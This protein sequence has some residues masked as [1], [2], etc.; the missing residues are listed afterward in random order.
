M[1]QSIAVSVL[2]TV[3]A[4]RA[5][6]L[7]AATAL[8]AL[9]L[10]CVPALA[11]TLSIVTKCPPDAV[12][13]GQTCV[14]TYEASVWSVPNP[15]TTN[16]GLIKKII[17]GKVKLSDLGAGS[18]TQISFSLCTPAFPGTFPANGQW[19]Q[20]LYAVSVAGVHPTACVTW[21]QADQACRLSGKRLL[22]NGEWQSAAAGTPDGSGGDNGTT[23]CNT[24]SVFDV[25]NTGSRANCK[26]SWGAFDMVGNVTEWVQDWVPLSPGTCPGWSNFSGNSMCLSGAQDTPGGPGALLRGG[27]CSDGSNAGPFYVDGTFQPW[28]VRAGFG[29]RCAR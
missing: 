16:K 13:V 25:V 26:S 7:C 2:R 11:G 19:T 29:F 14:D 21:F 20:P 17:G 9:T 28:S 22:T 10:L 1:K 5:T 4:L 15:T 8:S 23:D 3:S 6:V 27:G 24:A 18:A 12:L